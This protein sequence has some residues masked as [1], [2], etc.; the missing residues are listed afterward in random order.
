M[1]TCPAT[2]HAEAG[3]RWA[4]SSL[5]AI[6][7]WSSAYRLP[8]LLP[9]RPCSTALVWSIAALNFQRPIQQAPASTVSIHPSQVHSQFLTGLQV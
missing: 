6:N 8:A 5:S 1:S 4:K 7:G 2:I 9:Q 3:Q